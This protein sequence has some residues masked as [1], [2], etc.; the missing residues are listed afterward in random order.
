ML[1]SFFGKSN[2]INYLLLAIF[3]L[4]GYILWLIRSVESPVELIATIEYSAFAIISVF[5]MLLLDFIIR[6]NRLTKNN[7]YG[8]LFF[9]CFL[10]SFQTILIEKNI[11]IATVF[12]LLALRRILSLYTLK[13]TE[14]KILDA[15]IWISIA[16]FFYFW[17]LLFFLLLYFALFLKPKTNYKQFIIPIG[18]FLGMFVIRTCLHILRADSFNWFSEWQS[19]IGIDFSAYNEGAILLPVTVM[20]TFLLWTGVPRL[21]RIPSLQKNE[22]IKAVVVLL[23]LI[24]T[25]SIAMAGPKKTGGELL[26]II[27]PLAIII[28]NYLE[29]ISE[30]WF[31][32]LLLW[33]ALLIPTT[34]FLL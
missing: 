23:S 21:I 27:G 14:K 16:S 24:I 9:S 19:E 15:A 28:T 12:I 2:P 8:I 7:T 17:C 30:F 26:F 10:I 32:E 33:L 29:S 18:G 34:V 25:I 1:T 20:A 13:N 22:R 31:K 3:I 11:L 6:K 5:S 4:T